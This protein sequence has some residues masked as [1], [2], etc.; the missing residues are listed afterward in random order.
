MQTL[1]PTLHRKLDE[2]V[3]IGD[4]YMEKHIAYGSGLTK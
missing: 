4:Y 2:L 1:R 3:D